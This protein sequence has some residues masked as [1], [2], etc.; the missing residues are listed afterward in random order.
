MSYEAKGTGAGCSDTQR[1]HSEVIAER[2][3][4]REVHAGLLKEARKFVE[5]AKNLPDSVVGG[6]VL[7]FRAAIARAEEASNE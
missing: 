5:P 7:R 6:Q 4:L 3:R 2:D 1:L